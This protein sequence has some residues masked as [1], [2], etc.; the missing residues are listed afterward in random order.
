MQRSSKIILGI[1]IVLAVVLAAIYIPILSD[2]QPDLS[3][4]EAQKML[5]GLA[6]SFIR[7]SVR[8]VL[9]Y[10]SP[11][12]EV[13]GKKLQEIRDLLRKFFGFAKNLQVQFRDTHFR[14]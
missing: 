7:K 4:D 5:N 8:D 3:P 12:A 10:A 13:A 1:C 11:D 14:R 6:D 2:T 9:S